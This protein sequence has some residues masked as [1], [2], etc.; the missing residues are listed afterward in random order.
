M[1]AIFKK[2]L[3]I[4]MT[5]FSNFLFADSTDIP[6]Y[7]S[8][9]TVKESDG[10]IKFTI[11]LEKAPLSLLG[12]KVDY[13]TR[14]GT[15]SANTDYEE[16]SGGV[17]DWLY[18]P[19]GT[20]SRD[21]V[22]DVYDDN[23]YEGDLYFYLD[24]TTSAKGYVPN[25]SGKGTITDD[26]EDDTIKVDIDSS[27][28]QEGDEGES[29]QLEFRI[30]LTKEYP[31]NTPL[32]ITY[33]TEDGSDPSAT[34]GVDYHAK[35]GTVTFN[36][37]E[38]EKLIYVDIIGDDDI[39]EDENVKMTISGSDLIIDHDSTAEILN[40]DGSF[41]PISFTHSE[42]SIV[43]GH[44]GQK[45]LDF[46][47]TLS[48]PALE[49][50][51]FTYDTWDGSAED[52]S[53]DN[54]YL[55]TN[56]EY[57]L[58]AGTQKFSISVPINGDTKKE[59]DEYFYF[60]IDN[61]KKLSLNGEDEAVGTI[62]NDDGSF[63]ALKFTQ[64]LF[65]IIEG[66]SGQKD[67]NFTLTFDKPALAGSS[68]DFT[69]QE[70]DTNG[71]DYIIPSKSTI[72]F[73]GGERNVTIPI[74]INGDN[75]VESDERFSIKVNH[76]VNLSF[77]GTKSVTG[78]II[79]DDFKERPFT[80]NEASYL[81]T[82]DQTANYT[83]YYSINLSSGV[84]NNEKRFGTSHINA[85]GYNIKD[86][87]IYGFEYGN[88]NES[89]PD[90]S[91]HVVRINSDFNIERLNI[92]GLSK[93]RFYL[94]DVSMDGIFYLANRHEP[95]QDKN[96][97][98]EIQRVDLKTKILIS[99]IT[100]QYD[101]NTTHILTSDF[102]FNPKDNQLYM[103]N[104]ENNQLIRV[105]K[106][107][108]KVEE[109]GYV[110]N[111]G[112]TYSVIN[113]FDVDGNFYFYTKGTEKIYKIDISNPSTINAT[114][115]EFNDMSGVINSG[116]GARCAN[117]PV[118]PPLKVDEPLL[119]DN[120]MYLSSSIKR[121]TGDTGRMWLH[122][123]DTQKNPFAF[124]VINEA[125]DSRLYNALAYS[126]A[127]D[128]NST[129]FIFGLYN[130]ELIKIGKAGKAM[131]LGKIDSLS[132]LLGSRQFFAGAA[133]NGYYYI[134]GPGVDYDKIFKIRLSDKS[135]TDINLSD[136]ISLLDFSFT[137][138]GR[139]LHGVVDGG[140]LVKIDVNSGNVTK[141]GSAHTGYE[142]DSSF[143]DKT[144]RFFANDSKG[145]GFFEFDLT[146]G[147]KLFLS[148]S[149]QASFND[150]ANCLKAALLFTDYGDAPKSYGEARHNIAN[151][152]FMGANVDHDIH[153]YSNSDATGDDING[154]DDEDGVTLLDGTDI[155]GT[156]FE[157]D[158][159][160]ELNIS[161]SKDGYLHAWLDFNINGIFDSSEKIIT[162][163]SLTAGNHI[164]TFNIPKSAK[165]GERT[166]IRFR[167][168]STSS[169]NATQ[170]TTDG[171]V[172]DYAIQLGTKS[173]GVPGTFN[174]ER[175]GSHTLPINSNE[176]NAWYTQIVGKDFD[177]HV[178]FYDENMTREKELINLPIKIELIDQD[179]LEGNNTIV[180][181]HYDYFS[182][183]STHKSRVVVAKPT[184]SQDLKETKATKRAIFRIIYPVFSDGSTKQFACQAG[185]SAEE[186][187]KKATTPHPDDPVNIKII[188]AKD[189]F[190]IR[191]DMFHLTINDK[192]DTRLN[193]RIE[194]EINL[195]AGYDYNLTVTATKYL[196]DSA[197]KGYTKLAD[198]SIDMNS[199]GLTCQDTS[200]I[201]E[202]IEFK[203][204]LFQD[205]L[206]SHDNVGKYLLKIEDDKSWTE[207]DQNST[208]LGCIPDS[209]ERVANADGKVGCDIIVDKFDTKLTFR[210][211]KFAIDLTSH[212][213]P[214]NTHSDFIYMSDL[215]RNY[216]D[217]A[218]QFEGNITALTKR[219]KPTSN[220][221]V[222]CMAQNITLLPD[223]SL[224][225]EDGVVLFPNKILTAQYDE[226]R[227]RT[228]VKISRM[229]R[230]NSEDF[231]V[232]TINKIDYITE[233]LSI[234]K[235]K[236]LNEKNGTVM[237]DL[238]YNI[239]KKLNQPI[240]PIQVTFNS[241]KIEASLAHSDANETTNFIPKGFK[242]LGS[243]V[244]NFYFAQVAPDL[245]N[246]PRVNFQ[247]IKNL[248]TPLNVDIFCNANRAYCR[249]TQ[250][251]NNTN[252]ESSPRKQK[253][254]F[255]S[256][257]HDK[258]NDGEVISLI[259]NRANV[260]PPNIPI[261]FT[262][263]RDG[264]L[265]TRIVSCTAPTITT[266][267][268]GSS[269][270][271]KYNPHGNVPYYTVE[272][273]PTDPSEWTGIGL[274]GNVLDVK[275]NVK[276]GGKMDW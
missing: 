74:K 139:Y 273:T 186:C 45:M 86:D 210:P 193:S 234:K 197:S 110:G 88:D 173:K 53:K 17:F 158:K 227:S 243:M 100:L 239:Q 49:G 177:Y 200:N 258:N 134:S 13:K 152:L 54:D 146:T 172:E 98:Q 84:A 257:H 119:C 72:S 123:I 159:N 196:T 128:A 51:S 154:S 18:F 218:I 33:Q 111:I 211:Y 26:E 27:D 155:N 106:D 254:W 266:I 176:R 83:D 149:Q 169:L 232:T 37:G 47:F 68:F 41:P 78:K 114:A 194:K 113:F 46:N 208:I 249:K 233:T 50:A 137:P 253:G 168:A 237:L 10:T 270:T 5:L 143:S 244:R 31:L 206:F 61:L 267:A 262:L 19:K 75:E 167:Y 150:G 87:Y 77:E 64:T 35:S 29:N 124:N 178:V 125:G 164:I 8:S 60:G 226:N 163:Q 162:G 6:I 201:N 1:N 56:G 231:N 229:E 9:P 79:N 203:D 153:P 94:G 195:A 99:K 147:E 132:T 187:Y 265:T 21:L 188:Y 28:I 251:F 142:F 151:G 246:Y 65:S 144:G 48:E 104:A 223:A 166:Y 44:S 221:T 70:I 252:L 136:A 58:T 25:T 222:G 271:L 69:L 62:I 245:I 115:T 67:L 85:T 11:T 183:L 255:L 276:G 118:T 91:Y 180:P 274:T 185:L 214:S 101:Q 80:C 82:S 242:N 24:A 63:P 127:G 238:R 89:D 131:N 156:T 179:L 269:P 175:V 34:A 207:V 105:N 117:A 190:S 107:S 109:L 52:E 220:F 108:G 141:I 32:T 216:Y 130:D 71:S 138:D 157:V 209:G 129:N 250:I 140:E 261:K 102:A 189:N 192:N 2:L 268:I 59:E 224:E 165:Q 116:D 148:A 43:E 112:N 57:N 55:W 38:R 126:D 145:N 236:F 215:S 204:G 202:P 174:I 272:C 235:D 135:V 81:F 275:S 30:F 39:E 15:A 120:T 40:D 217:T 133:Y 230:F 228:E 212:D 122:K 191:P 16:K 247:Q 259:P 240:N 121:G 160:Q 161:V 36:K 20:K 260:T 241:L 264:T 76:E 93:T 92:A 3:L 73:A 12:M 219:S 263:G 96:R 97:L 66:N 170:S 90:N 205:I 225:S 181:P 22:L 199:S 42:F 4:G 213:L 23:L 7:V 95:I 182:S 198:S 184:Y 171:E 248:S 103:I 14:N 256:I